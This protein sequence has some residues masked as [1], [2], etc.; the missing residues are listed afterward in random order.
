MSLGECDHGSL[1]R[2][3]ELCE[4]DERIAALEAENARLKVASRVRPG[5]ELRCSACGAPHWIDTSI[6]S[7]V[8]NRIAEPH[9]ILCML[10][11]DN[12]LVAKGLTT[13]AEFY[14]SGEG[15]RSKLYD[16]S[17]GD[18]ERIS[19]AL[20]AEQARNARLAEA[21]QPFAAMA[22]GDQ[23]LPDAGRIVDLCYAARR[24]LAAAALFDPTT[25]LAVVAC[26]VAA[27][28]VCGVLRVAS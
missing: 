27:S 25:L 17:Q 24:A 7:D 8:W 19:R 18:V 20:A 11:I 1:R 13:P 23:A 12:R 2:K 10:C 22:R 28:L 21:L 15:L 26:L 5:Y 3:C 14:F 9:D 6:P 16:E 4:R